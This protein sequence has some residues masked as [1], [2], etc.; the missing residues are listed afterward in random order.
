M[1]L[2]SKE[3]LPHALH[4]RLNFP[5]LLPK[6]GKFNLQLILVESFALGVPTILEQV[7]RTV[8]GRV[9]SLQPRREFCASVP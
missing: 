9:S 8:L 4:K 1:F 7:S 5:L 6:F 2:A 3:F